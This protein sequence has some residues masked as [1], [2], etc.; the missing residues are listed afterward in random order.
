MTV[1]SYKSVSS[2]GPTDNTTSYSTSITAAA[3]TDCFFIVSGNGSSPGY[4][5]YTYDG[6]PM[7]WVVQDY[8]YGVCLN[9]FR[10]R[11]PVVGSSKT[12]AWTWTNSRKP[13]FHVLH[14]GNTEGLIYSTTSAANSGGLP[15]WY[16]NVTTV[17]AELFAVESF[18]TTDGTDWNCYPDYGQ[19]DVAAAATSIDGIYNRHTA[20]D[21]VSGGT[22]A[23]G[24]HWCYCIDGGHNQVHST[25]WLLEPDQMDRNRRKTPVL[26]ADVWHQRRA[27]IG[28]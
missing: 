17:S 9:I 8:S 12:I 4:T 3:G 10:Y 7:E 11:K 23:F 26:N 24:W 19:T 22:D 25:V 13:Y 21:T 2:I 16:H 18:G 14:L 28:H 15:P 6:N 1:V 27:G 20:Y 5:A